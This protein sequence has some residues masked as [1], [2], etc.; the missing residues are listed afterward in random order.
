MALQENY[1]F[2]NISYL[3]T[4][5]QVYPYFLKLNYSIP[6]FLLFSVNVMANGNFKFF[7]FFIF[8]GINGHEYI[9][10]SIHIINEGT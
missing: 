2:Y 7:I 3:F 6:F 9:G 8:K 10:S 5:V 4:S 1:L